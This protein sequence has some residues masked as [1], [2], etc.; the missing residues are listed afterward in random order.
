[1]RSASSDRDALFG[2]PNQGQGNGGF[3]SNRA[4][5]VARDTQKTE[6][7]D[8]RGLLDQQQTIMRDQDQILDVLA[9]SVGRQKEIAISIDTELTEQN[10]LLDDLDSKV[11]RTDSGIRNA[12]HRVRKVAEQA[13]T[14]GMWGVICFLV[15]A[16]IV[17]SFLA[18]YL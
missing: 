2:S 10:M 1:M 16:L 5:G 17:V 9:Q 4:W 14:K 12:T 7:L 15:L 11:D 18:V 3:M 13:S 6:D 8:N